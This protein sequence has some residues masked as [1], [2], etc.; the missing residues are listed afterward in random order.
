VCVTHV[1]PGGFAAQAGM[2]AG[3][4]L[5]WLNGAPVMH[6]AEVAFFIREHAPGEAFDVEY[7]RGERVLR[8]RAP[9]SVW[10]FGTGTYVGHPGGYPKPA[11][12]NG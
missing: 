7:L 2:Q 10:N 6:T 3:D 11:L 1:V 5:L 12:I 4:L 8:G 9:L